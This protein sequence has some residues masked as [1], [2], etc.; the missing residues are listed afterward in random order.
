[1]LAICRMLLVPSAPPPC[2]LGCSERSIYGMTVQLVSVSQD[3]NGTGLVLFAHSHD[4]YSSIRCY[5]LMPWRRRSFNRTNDALHR[6]ARE[7][8]AGSGA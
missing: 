4:R 7:S 8:V 3:Q 5:D 6:T 1:M 2:M